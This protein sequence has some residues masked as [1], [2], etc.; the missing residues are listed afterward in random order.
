MDSQVLA[1]K[2]APLLEAALKRRGKGT[3][4]LVVVPGTSHNLKAVEKKADAGFAGPVVAEALEKIA[5]WLGAELG[6]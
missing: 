1:E 4:E 6:A 2:D 5:A 3:T